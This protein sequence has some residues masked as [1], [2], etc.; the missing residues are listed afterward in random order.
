MSSPRIRRATT[1]GAWRHRAEDPVVS[2]L[3]MGWTLCHDWHFVNG[4]PKK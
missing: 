2:A 1:S 3:S 4:L